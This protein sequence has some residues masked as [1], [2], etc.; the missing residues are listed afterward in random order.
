MF[1]GAEYPQYIAPPDEKYKPLESSG[2]Q[3]AEWKFGAKFVKVECVNRNTL[4]TLQQLLSEHGIVYLVVPQHILHTNAIGGM[5]ANFEFHHFSRQR[6]NPAREP[7][8]VFVRDTNKKVHPFATSIQG[9][10]AVL[11]TSDGYM[12][13]V[14]ENDYAGNPHIKGI[15]GAVEFGDGIYATLKKEL[16][17]EVGYN[18]DFTTAEV[19][20]AHGWVKAAARDTYIADN[21]HTFLLR[22]PNTKDEVFENFNSRT[23]K[24]VICL[25]AIRHDDRTDMVTYPIYDNVKTLPNKLFNNISGFLETGMAMQCV[26]SQKKGSTS[27][28]FN[29]IVRVFNPVQYAPNA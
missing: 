19:F 14:V 9:V 20:L 4:P 11:L 17:E 18:L 25:V 1:R 7:A 23:D 10:S 3:L 8:L 29:D 22:V 16:Q 13:G 6:D 26:F 24:E 15:S 28:V 21:F 12:I 27:L 5:L 2:L